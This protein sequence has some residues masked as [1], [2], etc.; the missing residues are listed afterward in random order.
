M[1]CSLVTGSSLL[2]RSTLRAQDVFPVAA[3]NRTE[4]TAT[5]LMRFYGNGTGL[6]QTT[7]F[8]LTRQAKATIANNRTS[9]DQH[10]LRWAGPADRI[11]AARQHSALE[12]LTAAL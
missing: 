12:V 10:G 1:T 6:W 2:E 5:A 7:G 9:L 11:D 8:Y 3:N 4:A